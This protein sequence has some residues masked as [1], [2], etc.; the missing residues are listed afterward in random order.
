MSRVDLC[1]GVAGGDVP[2]DDVICG[3]VCC[4]GD[5]LW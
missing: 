5:V 1:D 4:D 3:D 2:S